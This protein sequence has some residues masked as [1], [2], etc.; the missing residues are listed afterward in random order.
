MSVAQSTEDFHTNAEKVPLSLLLLS[1]V[2]SSGFAPSLVDIL[3]RRLTID[4]RRKL[5][6]RYLRQRL[7]ASK[8][9]DVTAQRSNIRQAA[10]ATRASGTSRNDRQGGTGSRNAE[11]GAV[12]DAR[13]CLEARKR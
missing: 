4:D 7:R 9:L 5:G 1:R 11:T 10:T 8:A 2:Y 6:A 3:A 13:G 12:V